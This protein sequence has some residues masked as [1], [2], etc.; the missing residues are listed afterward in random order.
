M[1]SFFSKLDL[2]KVFDMVL[3]VCIVFLMFNN[4]QGWGWLLTLLFVRS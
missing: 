1:K 2:D 4:I 3:L